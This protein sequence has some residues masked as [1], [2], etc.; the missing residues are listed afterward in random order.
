MTK[1][2]MREI[3]GRHLAK[4][5]TWSYAALSERVELDRKTGDC[6]EHFE[7]SG[8]DGTEYQM[9][10]NAFWDDRPQ[11]DIRVAGSFSAVPQRRLLGFLPVFMPHVTDSFI[12]SPDGSFVDENEEEANRVGGSL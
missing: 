5:R 3:L 8:T 6:L 12:M 1:D 4:F 11:A 2:E 10:F 9:E 7:G